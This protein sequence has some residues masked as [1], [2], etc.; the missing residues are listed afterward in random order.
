MPPGQPST[1]YKRSSAHG[2]SPYEAHCCLAGLSMLARQVLEVT[3]DRK[4]TGLVWHPSASPPLLTLHDITTVL[5]I[6]LDASTRTRTASR[7]HTPAPH[8]TTTPPAPDVPV[9]VLAPAASRC[10]TLPPSLTH[11]SFCLSSAVLCPQTRTGARAGAHGNAPPP[12]RPS[13]W[14][15][16]SLRHFRVRWRG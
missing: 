6:Q 2:N 15:R 3:L 7:P 4:P 11:P 12:R 1:T 16:P 9:P 13:T 8:G 10:C 5:F 14:P